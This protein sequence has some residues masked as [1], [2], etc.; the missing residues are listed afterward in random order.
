MAGF[1]LENTMKKTTFDA[2]ELVTSPMVYVG[3]RLPKILIDKI[4]DAAQADDPSAPNRSS[5][6]RRFLIAGLKREAA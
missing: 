5:L 4:D 6:M 3:I 2:D 1:S